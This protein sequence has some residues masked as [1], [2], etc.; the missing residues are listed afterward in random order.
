M[1]LLDVYQG[2][3]TWKDFIDGQASFTDLTGDKSSAFSVGLAARDHQVAVKSGLGALNLERL[4]RASENAVRLSLGI[5]KLAGGLEGLKADFNLLLGDLIWRSE[6]RQQSV[7]SILEEIRLAEFERE[8]RA[9]RTRADRAY[10][11]GWYEEALGDFLEAEKRN[12][13]DYS[14][15]RSIAQIYLYHRSNLPKALDYFLKAAKYARPSD[16]AGAAESHYFAGIVYVV[17]RQLEP[18]MDHLRQATE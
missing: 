13:P 1:G 15:H 8:A 9:Y 10:L 7:T 6:M 12:Y 17:E 3:Q 4:R 2:H 18:A 5:E 16:L 11:N 14:V